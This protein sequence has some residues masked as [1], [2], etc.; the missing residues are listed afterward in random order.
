MLLLLLLLLT[1]LPLLHVTNA[2]D[3]LP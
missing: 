1:H 2:T 3:T